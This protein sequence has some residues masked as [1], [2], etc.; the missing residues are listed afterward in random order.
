MLAERDAD[1]VLQS[2]DGLDAWTLAVRH[3]QVSARR[4]R[5]RREPDVVITA[6]VEVLAGVVS[7]RSSGV[8]DFLDGRLTTRGDLSLALQLDGLFLSSDRPDSHPRAFRGDVAGLACAWL[9]A[10]PR[11]APP[12]VLLHGLGA[13]NASMLPTLRDLSADHRVLS[14]DLPGFGA[15]AAP[16][17]PYDPE[18]FSRFVVAFCE[19]TDAR[20]V[21][22]VG[23]SLGGRVA[24]ETALRAPDLVRGTVLYCASPA[25][26]KLRLLAPVARLGPPTLVGAFPFAPSH[27]WVVEFIRFMFS[28]SSRLPDSWFDGAADEFRRVWRSRAHRRAFL[29]SLRQIVAE[30]GDGER[31]FYARLESLEVPSL[32]LWGARDRLVPAGFARHVE[33]A[34]PRSTSVVLDDCGHVPHFEDPEQ[35]H[36]LTREHLAGLP[37]PRG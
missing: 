36:R 20:D 32:F 4:G 24:L 16:R 21:V 6:E 2:P 15:S 29:S 26:R 8:V 13:T 3:G 22:L 14:P 30:S 19:A 33:R 35:T 10:G 37:D 28:D 9:E 11:D 31:G 17:A 18:W 23:N 27:A 25:W 1:V 34:V 5:E 7:G 12:V